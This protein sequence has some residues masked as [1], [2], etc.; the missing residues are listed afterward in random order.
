MEN[1]LRRRLTSE[2]LYKSLTEENVVLVEDGSEEVDGADGLTG[3]VEVVVDG[4]VGVL[5][6][7][8]P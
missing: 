6:H 3:V 8:L 5:D 1:E 2:N 7:V 4:E